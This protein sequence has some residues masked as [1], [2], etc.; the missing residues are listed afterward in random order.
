M[1]IFDE[2]YRVVAVE[3]HRLTIRG[4]VSGK[5]FVIKTDPA[6]S[7]TEGD[8][9]LGKILALTDPSTAPSD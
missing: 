4:V 3:S 9:L 7:V 8:Y 5:V 2:N 6:T 1:T